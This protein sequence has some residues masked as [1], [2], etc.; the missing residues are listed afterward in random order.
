MT[1]TIASDGPLRTSRRQSGFV[2]TPAGR[3]VAIAASVVLVL[4][5]AIV[6]FILGVNTGDQ[7]V[8]G[9][10]STIQRLQ[11]DNGKLTTDN[12]DLQAKLVD[13][14]AKLTSVQSTLDAIMPSANKYQIG[15]NQSLI[16]ADG[17][18]TIGLVGIPRND[19]VELNINSK[20]Y[21]AAAGDIINVAINPSMTCRVEVM[22]F[23]VL[24]A[25]VVVNATCGE[26]KL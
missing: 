3:F 10:K 9:S 5:I 21:P 26:A 8:A 2:T 4:G 6:S 7:E 23:D 20:Q 1:E 11:T 16:V 12:R 22:S 25:D 19:S 14:Q 18:L 24:K 13:L 17:H 15:P